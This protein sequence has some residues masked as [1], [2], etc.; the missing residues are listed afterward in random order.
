MLIQ[1]K[2]FHLIF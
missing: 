1:W 2:F